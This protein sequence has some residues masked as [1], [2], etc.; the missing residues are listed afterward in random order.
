[1]A[2]GLVVT[3]CAPSQSGKDYMM[4][5][6]LDKDNWRNWNNMPTP[7]PATAW[8]MRKARKSDPSYTHCFENIDEVDVPIENQIRV[9]YGQQLMIYDKAEIDQAIAH[10]EIIIIATCVPQLC[11]EIKK[12]YGNN[13]LS[14]YIRN[15]P[16]S[17]QSMQRVEARRHGKKLNYHTITVDEEHQI[18]SDKRWDLFKQFEP[19]YIRH[20]KDAQKGADWIVTNWYT[21]LHGPWSTMLDDQADREWSTAQNELYHVYEAINQKNLTDWRTQSPLLVSDEEERAKDPLSLNDDFQE[22]IDRKRDEYGE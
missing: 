11:E 15:Q 10:G 13:S 7:K 22:Y 14:Y 4:T 8:K 2:Q 6:F 19:Q 16:Q 12:I 20:M 17:R 9:Y 18:E 5:K 1:M 3:I 21:L